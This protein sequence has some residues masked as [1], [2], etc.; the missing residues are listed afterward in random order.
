MRLQLKPKNFNVLEFL[1][2]EKGKN[3]KELKKDS[4]PSASRFSVVHF[5]WIKYESLAGVLAPF[6]ELYAVA[7][8]NRGSLS[9]PV[10]QHPN[11]PASRFPSWDKFKPQM[12]W[13]RVAAADCS[14]IRCAT[15]TGRSGPTPTCIFTT[16][17]RLPSAFEVDSSGQLA[18]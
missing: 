1:A 2:T 14:S 11:I 7:F 4:E 17:I 10:T 8:K 6:N 3:R 16:F 15:R 18:A 5:A 13:R 12:A 9:I